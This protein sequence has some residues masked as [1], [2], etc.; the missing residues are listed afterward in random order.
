[1]KKTVLPIGPFH[2][3]LE[4]PEFFTLTL[5]GE[6]VVDVDLRIGY[7]HRG[8]EKLATGLTWDQVPFLVERICGIC[9]TSHPYAY[10][11]A[12]ED[13]LG[14]KAPPRGQY[15]RMLIGELE[16]IHSHLLWLGLA[17][18]FIGYNTIW[19]WAWRYREEILDAC[20]KLSGNRNHYAMCRPGGSRRDV[21]QEA[22]D[23]TM[24]ALDSNEKATKMFL[25]AISD[26]PVMHKR[27]KGV[28]ILTKEDAIAYGATG[29]T[30]RPSGV[31]WDVRAD[32]PYD[33]FEESLE[34]K[35]WKVIV[36]PDGD[37]FAKAAARVLEI[38]E[39]I[40][41]CRWLIENMPD[42]DFQV[43][44]ENIPEGEGCGTHEAPRGEVF[45]YV[46]S[47]GSNKPIRHKVRAPTFVNLPTYKA[48]CIG[49]TISDVALITASIDPCYC[50]TERVGV[51]SKGIRKSLTQDDLVK[52]SVERTLEIEKKMGRK[53]VLRKF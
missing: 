46:R 49:E 41:L 12:V 28:G 47:D 9:S 37:V 38:L 10:V 21:T 3:L 35:A 22:M 33:A 45:H 34:A 26:D 39:S 24:K 42:G 25:G 30:S 48:T 32:D 52:L 51:V 31:P 2:P 6:T 50:C 53:S 18:H 13:L 17:G 16:R 14:I 7:N 1:M 43:V 15:I 20:E 36:L 8:H 19:M 29:P 11:L 40:K 23:F 44:P 5:D 27:L 4:E